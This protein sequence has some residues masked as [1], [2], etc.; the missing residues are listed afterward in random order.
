MVIRT[1]VFM[2]SNTEVG[3]LGGEDEVEVKH[4]KTQW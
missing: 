4:L 1:E 3:Y 2:G